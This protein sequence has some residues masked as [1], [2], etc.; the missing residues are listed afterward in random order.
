MKKITIS[1]L[2]VMMTAV[3]AGCGCDHK[4]KSATCEEPKT[5][6]LCGET[7]GEPLGHDWQDAT[8]ESPK[9]C[10]RCGETEGKPLGHDWEEATCTE[11]KKCRVCGET[12]GE[13]LGHDFAPATLDAPKTCKNCG[14]TEGNPVSFE[15]VDLSFF[16]DPYMKRA[17]SDDMC[18]AV[19]DTKNHHLK[20]VFYDLKGNVV[21]EHDLDLNHSDG[22]Y[23]GWIYS[24]AD[25]CYMLATGNEKG[26]DVT[27]YDYDFNTILEERLDIFACT[28]DESNTLEVNTNSF[29]GINRVYR[30]KDGKTYLGIDINNGCECAPEDFYDAASKYGVDPD[31]DASEWSTYVYKDSIKGFF[32]GT[33]DEKLW[34]FIDLD[35]NEIRMYKDATD[36]TKSGYA[37]VTNDGKS[38]D[39]IDTEFNVIKEGIVEA[40]GASIYEGT[41]MINVYYEDGSEDHY[42][43]R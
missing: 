8:C 40:S 29:D 31:Y 34:G 11:P 14:E 30:N 16:G 24:F 10:A 1:L 43:V 12:K 37:L 6:K 41:N 25:E 13:P 15:K 5:C 22:S 2:I 19:H 7:E 32:V 18:V 4:W 26:T 23:D 36:F 28:G 17:I 35:G 33:K 39:L 20:V 3:L 38:Y 42:I 27:V 9:T 21:H